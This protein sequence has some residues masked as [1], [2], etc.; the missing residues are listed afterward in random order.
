MIEIKDL[1]VGFDKT[2]ILKEINVTFSE[3]LV[4]G[5]IG[6][7]GSGKTTFFR[8]IYKFIK[9]YEGQILYRGKEITR[10][11]VAYLPMENFFYYNLTGREYLNVIQS[12]YNKNIIKNL[13]N[14]FEVPLNMLIKKYSSGMKKKLA[15]LGILRL[16]RD[17][18]L[19][20]EPFNGLDIESVYVLKKII[21]ILRKRGKTILITSHITEV[22]RDLCNCYYYL[23]SGEIQ[24]I[25]DYDKSAIIEEKLEEKYNSKLRN[26]M[27]DI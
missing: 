13:E 10:S 12:S 2:K 5:I 24:F 27:D 11:D 9:N 16:D 21:I 19:L 6:N 20:D 4:H 1:T 22:L 14:L 26:L 23:E 8:T 18:L 3:G 15:L 17:I 25:G 7:N